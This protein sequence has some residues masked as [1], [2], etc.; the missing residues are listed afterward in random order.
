MKLIINSEIDLDKKLSDIYWEGDEGKKDHL[1]N[2]LRN[3][4]NNAL[5]IKIK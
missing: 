3:L 2:E 5:D 1:I 4:L